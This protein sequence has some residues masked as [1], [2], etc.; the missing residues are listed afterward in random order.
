M[1]LFTN[2]LFLLASLVIVGIA[3]AGISRGLVGWP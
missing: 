1:K 3:T 2:A